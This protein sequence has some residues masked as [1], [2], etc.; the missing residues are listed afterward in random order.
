MYRLEEE[1]EAISAYCELISITDDR[2][3]CVVEILYDDDDF[4]SLETHHNRS[5]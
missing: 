1:K 2:I 4:G 3:D 5:L